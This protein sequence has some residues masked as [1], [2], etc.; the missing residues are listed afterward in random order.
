MLIIAVRYHPLSSLLN[1]KYLY[2]LF[3]T[4]LACIYFSL[5]AGKTHEIFKILLKNL[6]I[7][8]ELKNN[9]LLEELQI[10]WINKAVD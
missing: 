1:L 5:R 4:L 8:K 6:K 10:K 7:R 2:K 3:L 9:P